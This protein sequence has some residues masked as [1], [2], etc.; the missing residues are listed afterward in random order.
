MK[1]TFENR[2]KKMPDKELVATYQYVSGLFAR[3]EE[4]LDPETNRIAGD[5]NVLKHEI[6]DRL[7]KHK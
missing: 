4:K 3:F 6:L 7:T 2:V 5:L 1:D